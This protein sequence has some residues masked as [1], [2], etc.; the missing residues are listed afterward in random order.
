[1]PKALVVNKGD[2]YNLLTIIKELN[3]SK[4]GERMFLCQCDCGNET[5]L[6]LG[7]IR[8][9]NTKSCGC[10]KI[11]T[12]SELLLKHSLSNHRL[13]KTWTNM[14]SRCYNK[15]TRSY[16]DYGARGIKVCDEWK[17]SFINFY[18]DMHPTYQEGLTIDS[19]NND[20]DYCKENCRWATATE[21]QNNKSTNRTVVHNGIEM[22]AK[23]LSKLLNIP[24]GTIIYRLDNNIKA[25]K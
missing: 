6:S 2:K 21:Q 24:Y 19:V 18:N 22:N 11:K 5:T 25:D 3:K 13:Y 10:L 12:S 23:Q 17:N 15:N 9:G 16:K 14:K 4:K 1:M 7:T 8:H 20:K